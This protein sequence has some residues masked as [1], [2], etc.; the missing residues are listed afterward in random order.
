MKQARRWGLQGCVA[1][2][3]FCAPALDAGTR[4]RNRRSECIVRQPVPDLAEAEQ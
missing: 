2:C 3:F 4:G 1:Y